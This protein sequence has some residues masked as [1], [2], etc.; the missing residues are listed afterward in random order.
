MIKEILYHRNLPIF[1]CTA[2][3]GLGFDDTFLSLVL[4]L[5]VT[6]VSVKDGTSFVNVVIVL[7]VSVRRL[8]LFVTTGNSLIISVVIQQNRR[9]R[10]YWRLFLF[11]F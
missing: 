11:I 9:L 2:G 5:F 6:A 3:L 1:S 10:L 8:G 4:W 7:A